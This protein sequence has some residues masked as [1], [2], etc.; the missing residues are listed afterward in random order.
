MGGGAG[1]LDGML[2]PNRSMGYIGGMSIS[3]QVRE[4]LIQ[5]PMSRYAVAKR[6]GVSQSLLSLFVNGKGGLSIEVLDQLADLLGL[7]VC[8]KGS[9]PATRKRGK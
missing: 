1:K 5:S 9:K 4:A 7:E 3:Q 8:P 6:L 2:D